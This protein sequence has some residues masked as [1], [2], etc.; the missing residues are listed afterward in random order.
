MKVLIKKALVVDSGSDFNGKTV[1]VLIDSGIIR[2]IAPSIA[3]QADEVVSGDALKI[4]RGW[5]DV[6]ANFCDPG[7]EFKE[8]IET[9]AAAAAAGG[10]TDVLI[11]P[12][13]KPALDNKSQIEYVRH[14]SVVNAVSVHPLGAI[15]KGTDGKELAEMYDMR[16]SGAAAFTDGIHPV[17]SSGLLLKA[18]QYVK[19][20]NGVIIQLPDDLSI[21]ANGLMHEG[22]VSTRLGLAGKPIM[23][24][25]L[26]VARD[27]KLVRYTGSRLH[28][29]G[30]TSP[31]SLEYIRRAKD[32]GMDVTCS[33]TPYHLFFTDE[34]LSAYDTNLKVYP[35][36]RTTAD[37][38][39]L[40]KAVL[41][42]T[43]D[44]ISSH[45]MPQEKDSKMVEFEYAK[46]G[47]IS[48]ETCFAVLNT[49]LGDLSDERIV[50]LFHSNAAKIFGIGSNKIAEGTR[51]SLT[52]FS[53]DPQAEVA[54]E[55]LRS[56]SKNSPFIGKTLRGKVNGI[57]NNEKLILN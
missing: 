46:N 9:G 52:I 56:K 47:M 17:Q 5:I 41:D 23:A 40:R 57:F 36:L 16:K 27:I 21:G 8:T 43:V 38:D 13:T 25:E 14:R 50:E 26:L 30:I 18:L 1:D 24:E 11:L 55:D 2:Q 45:H 54:I 33:I 6:F 20:F 4:S 3:E 35:P 39:A 31:K 37:R 12:N 34:D 10:F 51:A 28:F 32:A 29:T 53:R 49:V 7:Y 22:I 42:G 15:T 44:C 48:L 19:A